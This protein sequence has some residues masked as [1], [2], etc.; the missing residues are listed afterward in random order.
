MQTFESSPIHLAAPRTRLVKPR[1]VD[2][3]KKIL[4]GG[5]IR[6]IAPKQKIS[7]CVKDRSGKIYAE[8]WIPPTRF[9][10]DRWMKMCTSRPM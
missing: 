2:S 6:G 5:F 1:A 3:F 10:L 9:D 8:G 7:Y 4:D